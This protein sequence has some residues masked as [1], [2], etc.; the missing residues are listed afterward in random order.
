MEAVQSLG[1]ATRTCETENSTPNWLRALR[2]T[3]RAALNILLDESIQNYYIRCRNLIWNPEPSRD[4]LWTDPL[5]DVLCL[6]WAD[7]GLLSSPHTAPLSER[8]WT[9][10]WSCSSLDKA[11]K[12]NTHD[13]G[14]NP[15]RIPPLDLT[16]VAVHGCTWTFHI[17]KVRV[18]TL[19]ETLLLVPPLLLLRGWVQ[20][21]FCELHLRGKERKFTHPTATSSSSQTVSHVEKKKTY[22]DKSVR[23]WRM[24]NPSPNDSETITH[25]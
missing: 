13:S 15:A 10:S 9:P 2:W 14:Y 8:G 18:G 19:N 16:R 20:Q 24:W 23:N 5:W 3:A 21:V 6:R 12:K 25:F 4:G 17:H 11:R 1:S 7:T 22:S